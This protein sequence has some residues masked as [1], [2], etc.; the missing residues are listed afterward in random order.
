MT[1][2]SFAF[3]L[4]GLEGSSGPQVT[5][6]GLSEA[7]GLKNP[8]RSSSLPLLT[9]FTTVVIQPIELI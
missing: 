9:H 2:S 8:G 6:S 5:C 4:L 7:Q 3:D 1:N